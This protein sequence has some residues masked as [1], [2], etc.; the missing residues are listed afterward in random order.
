MTLEKEESPKVNV[1]VKD[2]TGAALGYA[3]GVAM[4]HNPS[5]GIGQDAIKYAYIYKANKGWV[6]LR[7]EDWAL[8]GPMIAEGVDVWADARED[9]Y[10]ARRSAKERDNRLTHVTGRT[11]QEAIARC[12]VQAKLG[13]DNID[14]PEEAL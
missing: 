9:E 14:V 4:E 10:H 2:L 8:I 1:L 13:K 6:E 3:I 5:I 7:V 12:W 11:P